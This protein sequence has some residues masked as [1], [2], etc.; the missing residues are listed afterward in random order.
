MNGFKK[1]SE[2]MSYLGKYVPVQPDYKV[3][4]INLAIE[5]CASTFFFGAELHLYINIQNLQRW[6]TVV[7]SQYVQTVTVYIN[8]SYPHKCSQTDL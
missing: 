3:K 8:V 7:R 4:S 1:Q 5:M 2:R 6:S